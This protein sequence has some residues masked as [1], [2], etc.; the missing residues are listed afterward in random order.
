MRVQ[1]WFGEPDTLF[2]LEAI[3]GLEEYL[4]VLSGI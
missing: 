3:A 1:E 2:R 4:R